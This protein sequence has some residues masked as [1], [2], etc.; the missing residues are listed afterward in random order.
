MRSHRVR[1]RR[2]AL[3]K[4]LAI[5]LPAFIVVA[6]PARAYFNDPDDA[7]SVHKVRATSVGALS[8]RELCSPRNY[9]TLFNPQVQYGTTAICSAVSGIDRQDDRWPVCVSP[10]VEPDLGYRYPRRVNEPSALITQDPATDWWRVC[11]TADLSNVVSDPSAGQAPC[12]V[13]QEIGLCLPSA[14]YYER[15][16][17]TQIKTPGVRFYDFV[18]THADCQTQ[19]T[20]ACSNCNDADGCRDVCGH[21]TFSVIQACKTLC[22]RYF[23]RLRFHVGAT[24]AASN[25]EIVTGTNTPVL[26]CD[27]SPSYQAPPDGTLA[28][29]CVNLQGYCNAPAGSPLHPTCNTTPLQICLNNCG[30]PFVDWGNAADAPPWVS[31]FGTKP[32]WEKNNHWFGVSYGRPWN[33]NTNQDNWLRSY[34]VNRDK[35]HAPSNVCGDAVAKYCNAVI[36][37]GSPEGTA[38][39]T[40]CKDNFLPGG[41]DFPVPPGDA[42]GNEASPFSFCDHFFFANMLCPETCTAGGTDSAPSTQ[43]FC[44]DIGGILGDHACRPEGGRD[45]SATCCPDDSDAP[46]PGRI[47]CC[48]TQTMS[49][50]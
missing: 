14:H 5:A 49:C 38:K 2:P 12:S 47:S 23:G 13:G 30:P 25:W 28:N 31:T 16:E 19:S 45:E 48:P 18:L 22:A 29:T 34:A 15:L 32:S 50:P 17:T 33:P 44:N 7:C 35:A 11:A 8:Y 1:D 20:P 37:L 43:H 21:E 40:K 42:N 27:Q 9:P 26:Q 41:W 46:C 36:P 39:R 6:A 4:A 10:G 24:A 3:G